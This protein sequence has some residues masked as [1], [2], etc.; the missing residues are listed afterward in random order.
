[1][2]RIWNS[3]IFVHID[4]RAGGLLQLRGAAD[5]IDMCVRDDDGFDA[6]RVAPEDFQDLGDVVAGI[7]NDGCVRLLVAE[8]GAV[9]L[10]HSDRQN[11][12]NHGR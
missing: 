12:M 9:A 11:F 10:E 3:V 5:V 7:D 6:Q 4:G 2:A 8:D 1:V